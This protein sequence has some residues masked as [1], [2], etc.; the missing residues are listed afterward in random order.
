MT[1]DVAE[2]TMADTT[3]RMIGVSVENVQKCVAF[4]WADDGRPVVHIMGGNGAGKSSILTA[5]QIALGGGKLVPEEVMRQG[6]RTWRSEVVLKTADGDETLTVVRTGR[7]NNT[8]T[9][10]ITTQA[11]TRIASPQALLDMLVSTLALDPLLFLAAKA[12]DQQDMLMRATGIEFD[13]KAHEAARKKHYDD[14][15][16]INR[17]RMR[18]GAE[19]KALGDLTEAK[20]VAAEKPIFITDLTAKAEDAAAQNAAV[21]IAQQSLDNAHERLLSLQAGVKEMAA[22]LE[23]RQAECAVAADAFIK[24]GADVGRMEC[25]DAGDLTLAVTDAQVHNHKIAIA[26][27]C[28]A[29]WAELKD[30]DAQ[31]QA[32]TNNLERLDAF[33]AKTLAAAQMPVE[34][35]EFSDNGLLYN[36]VPLAQAST[37]ESMTVAIRVAIAMHPK[38]RVLFIDEGSVLDDEHMALVA[39]VAEEHDLLVWIN[40]VRTD[41]PGLLIEDGVCRGETAV[42]DN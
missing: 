25:V 34:G 3:Y 12:T 17:E 41:R 11:N 42:A 30:W 31:S 38:L 32:E 16:T 35:L 28:V 10:S 27:S 8:G 26:E 33:K 15:T 40:S 4:E 14:R 6:A 36:G 22:K 1:K 39:N 2:M 23:Q 37:G 9:L 21:A 20:E 29:K 18:V 24:Q 13:A 7:S 5:I 19:A